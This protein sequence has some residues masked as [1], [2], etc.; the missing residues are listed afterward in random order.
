CNIPKSMV[1]PV[2]VV[3]LHVDEALSVVEKAI[4]NAIISGQDKLEIIHGSGTGRLKNA[5]RD[6]LKD[7]SY[8]RELKDAAITEGGGNKTIVSL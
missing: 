1:L 6:Y 5:I 3:G 8:V 7:L 2:V 4:D